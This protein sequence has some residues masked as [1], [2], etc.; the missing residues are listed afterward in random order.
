MSVTNFVRNPAHDTELY[1]T[2]LNNVSASIQRGL[3]N[4]RYL[5]KQKGLSAIKQRKEFGAMGLKLN[6][7]HYSQL[8]KGSRK[9]CNMTYIGFYA[10]YWG[11]EIG[12]FISRDMEKE[13]QMSNE[14]K[15]RENEIE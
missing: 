2:V 1:K 3:R 15:N 13:G 5:L 9:T 7:H 6:V 10:H 12:E 4:N 11:I 8:L 14:I